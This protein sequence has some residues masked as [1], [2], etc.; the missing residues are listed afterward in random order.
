MFLLGFS[1]CNLYVAKLF[2]VYSV[3]N[4][5]FGVAQL[6]THQPGLADSCDGLKRLRAFATV[7]ASC[8]PKKRS[9]TSWSPEQ[10]QSL[11]ELQKWLGKFS[12]K[13]YAAWT[14]LATEL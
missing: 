12:T 6:P 1:V 4:K 14:K 8:T 7:L 11:P 2:F 3:Q 10:Q 5:L 13:D 9:A